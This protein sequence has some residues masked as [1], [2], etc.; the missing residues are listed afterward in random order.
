VISALWTEEPSSPHCKVALENA[1]RHGALVVC[2]PVYC[3]LHACPGVTPEIISSFLQD[4]GIVADF[5][6][7]E[8]VWQEAALRFA[9][10]AN[11]RRRSGGASPKRMLVDFVV[12]AHAH[13]RTDC[14]LTLDQD[15]YSRDFPEL[16]LV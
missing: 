13:L 4:T 9:R 2:A 3:E 16:K 14:L 6:I 7:G 1:Q 8:D 11:R 5:E 10:Y 15:R 12:G